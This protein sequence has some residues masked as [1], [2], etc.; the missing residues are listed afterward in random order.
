MLSMEAGREKPALCPCLLLDC[1]QDKRAAGHDKILQTLV[2][3]TRLASS[4]AAACSSWLQSSSRAQ[5]DCCA[6][7]SCS[8]QPTLQRADRAGKFCGRGFSQHQV[9]RLGRMH[10]GSA[11]APQGFWACG[12]PTGSPPWE[13]LGGRQLYSAHALLHCLLS[14]V[15]LP[16]RAPS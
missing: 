10:M 5:I 7:P 14:C 16:R 12:A 11:S 6:Q 1:W 2:G 3:G 4:T 9:R 13:V 8:R 15:H